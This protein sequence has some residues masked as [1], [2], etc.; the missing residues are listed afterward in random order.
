MT[1][2]QTGATIHTSSIPSP[3]GALD[4]MSTD[5]ADDDENGSEYG[6]DVNF[7][8]NQDEHNTDKPKETTIK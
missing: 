7:C 8:K 2:T 6:L 4:T 1:A 3:P 5:A